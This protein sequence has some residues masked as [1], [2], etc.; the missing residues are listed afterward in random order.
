[1]NPVV[2]QNHLNTILQKNVCFTMND[3]VLREGKLMIYNVKDFYI[4]FTLIT[5]KDQQKIYEIPVPFYTYADESSIV[6][7][8]S[9]GY[10]TKKSRK[11]DY[12]LTALKNK[13]GK[14][15]K[16]FDSKLIIRSNLVD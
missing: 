8:Y 10:I 1:M 14:K 12:L 13:I 9:I 2:L 6:L 4:T 11:I 7:D 5:K 16:F 3:K 15:C